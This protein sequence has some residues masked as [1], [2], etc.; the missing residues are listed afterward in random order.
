[1]KIG[2][3]IGLAVL[4]V[5]S[6]RALLHW[7][8]YPPVVTTLVTDHGNFI[9]GRTSTRCLDVVAALKQGSEVVMPDPWGT[10]HRI[11]AVSCERG[12]ET[13]ARALPDEAAI[14]Q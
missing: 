8:E 14:E 13:I 1:M 12:N 9:V 11:V 10:T 6:G 4:G 2:K 5:V 7:H 3:M